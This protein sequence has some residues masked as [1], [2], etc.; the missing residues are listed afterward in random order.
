MKTRRLVCVMCAVWCCAALLLPVTAAAEDSFEDLF[1]FLVDLPGW[2]A[3]EP[4]GVDMRSSGMRMLGAERSYQ[5]GDSELKASIAVGQQAAA[6]WI[7][8]YQEGFSMRTPDGQV[9]VK[10]Q[11]GFLTASA[12]NSEDKSGVL[13]ILLADPAKE[14]PQ[15]GALLSI[16]YEDL[17]QSEAVSIAKQFDWKGIQKKVSQFD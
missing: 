4:D 17:S 7:P 2:D 1:P 16:S 9:E 12:Y 13:I 8:A 11:N 10:R 5:K 6:L 15:Q 14:G 3:D